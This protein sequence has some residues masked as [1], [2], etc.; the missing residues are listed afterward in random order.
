MALW[1]IMLAIWLIV[2]GIIWMTGPTFPGA[3]AIEGFLAILAAIFLIIK[4]EGAV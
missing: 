3:F 1:R 2:S 4:P